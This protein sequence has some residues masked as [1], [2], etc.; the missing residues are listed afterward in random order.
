MRFERTIADSNALWLNAAELKKL[1]GWELKP[2]E[3]PRRFVRADSAG[4]RE[5]IHFEA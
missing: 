2:E 3:L 5:R 1:A 4:T